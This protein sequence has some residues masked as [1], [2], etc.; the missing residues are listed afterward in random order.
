MLNCEATQ[1]L[2]ADALYAPL[3]KEQD[4]DLQQHLDS[5]ADCREL[6]LTLQADKNVLESSGIAGGN[7]DDI[8][9][10]AGLDDLWRNIEPALDSIDAERF[11]QR[12]HFRPAPYIGAAVAIAASVL[13]FFSVLSVP[14]VGPENTQPA[15]PPN[16]VAQSTQISPELL[17]YLTRVETMLMS[18]ANAESIDNN[19]VPVQQTFARDMAM[20][21]NFMT[22]NLDDSFSSGQS[23]LLKDIEFM[24][25]QIANLDESN[26]EEGVQLLQ[27][28][29][30]DNSVLLKIRL[31]EMRNQA[32]V[33]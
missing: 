3:P 6:M 23:R 4:H 25:L 19:M 27:Q 13:V 8:P 1:L 2:M 33:I 24:L 14:V 18:V 12:A 20:Q 26:M 21:A 17:S 30:D 32:E 5:C 11:R 7:F 16:S 9:E 31:M 29:M 28:Y 10:R 15:S 22:N